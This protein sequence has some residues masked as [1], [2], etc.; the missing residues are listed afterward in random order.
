MGLPAICCLRDSSN[1]I[2][3]KSDSSPP[4]LKTNISTH[5]LPINSTTILSSYVR[6]KSWYHPRQLPPSPSL[7]LVHHQ[8]SKYLAKSLPIFGAIIT[9]L[10]QITTSGCSTAKW[11]VSTLGSIFLGWSL[12]PLFI[13]CVTLG[14]S[15]VL[16]VPQFPHL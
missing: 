13:S 5:A 1:S 7:C 8:V 12:A 4:Y 16:S 3:L 2:N 6:H 15:L 14:K 10:V 11:W 9:I